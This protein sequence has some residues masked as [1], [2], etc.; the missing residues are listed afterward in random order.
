MK[1]PCTDFVRDT[2]RRFHKPRKVK[3]AHQPFYLLKGEVNHVGKVRRLVQ[4]HISAA[5][6]RGSIIT[7]SVVTSTGRALLDGYPGVVGEIVI[8]DTFWAKSLL[9][10]M[11]TVYRVKTTSKLPIPEGA[12][13][14]AGLLFHHNIV[15]KVK[16][17]KIP[18]ALILNLDQTPSKYVAVAQTTLAKKNLK[19]VAITG[20]SDR[21]S[22]TA[23]FAVSFDGTF[24][25]MQLIYGG[26]GD[27][28]LT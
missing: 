24:L 15:S 16:R 17:H 20:G 28:K 10:R 22:I 4:R 14:E 3:E 25:P 21:C 27:S 2:K 26:K 11:G 9:Q 6:N 13:K 1:V 19:S 5:S 23:T 18:C 12:I 8:E 7:R